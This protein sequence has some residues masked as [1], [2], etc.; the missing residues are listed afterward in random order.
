MRR[1]WNITTYTILSCCI[2]LVLFILFANAYIF[3][4]RRSIVPPQELPGMAPVALVFGGGMQQD[5][6][7]TI[8]QEDRVKQAIDLYQ[9][10]KVARL[11]M[12]GDDGA[13]RVDEVHPMHDYAVAAGVPDEQVD[14]DP[15]GYNTFLSCQRAHDEFGVTSTIVVSQQFHLPR[16]IYFCKHE[17][18]QTIGV[19]ADLQA[20]DGWRTRVWTQGLREILARVKGFMRLRFI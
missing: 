2:L 5:G 20:Y 14:I 3:S 13:N 10:G 8:L 4:F 19:T 16:I 6:S 11:I 17:G 15:H 1:A 12:T 18:I 9:Q 7:M